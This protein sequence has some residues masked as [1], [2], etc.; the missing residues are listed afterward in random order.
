MEGGKIV[1]KGP[2]YNFVMEMSGG[3]LKETITFNGHTMSRVSKKE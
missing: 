2:K 3:K 1:A